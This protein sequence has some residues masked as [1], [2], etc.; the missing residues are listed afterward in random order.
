MRH[1]ALVVALFC[2]SCASMPD[3]EGEGLPLAKSGWRL[4][5]GADFDKKVWFVTFWRPWGQAET[6]AAAAADKIVIP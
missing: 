6:Q 3:M 2:A 1:V 4:A 5:G